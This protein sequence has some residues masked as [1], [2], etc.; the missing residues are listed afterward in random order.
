M[1][2]RT[3]GGLT[4][5]DESYTPRPQNNKEKARIMACVAQSRLSKYE[6]FNVEKI[7]EGE[8]QRSE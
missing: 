7:G 2:G 5:R 4:K 6:N 3:W 8:K 1:R